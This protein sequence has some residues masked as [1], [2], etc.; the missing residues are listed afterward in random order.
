MEV[1]EKRQ[2]FLERDKEYRRHH[3]MKHPFV[4]I[5]KRLRNRDKTSTVTPLDLWKIAKRQ[6]CKCALTGR[7]L[8]TENTSPDHIICLTNGGLTVAENIR[9]VVKDVNNARG[10]MNDQVFIRLCE[11]VLHT[12]KLHNG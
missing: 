11:D 9:L 2:K 7:K 3:W 5:S 12:Y 6:N 4:R 8:T 1:V 10:M